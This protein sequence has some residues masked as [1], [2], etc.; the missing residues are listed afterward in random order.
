MRD[1]ITGTCRAQDGARLAV[2]QLGDPQ[3][4]PLLLLPGQA[5]SHRWW[6]RLRDELAAE[7]RTI[8]FDYR[9]TGDS[10]R[11]DE[12]DER[13]W[14]TTVFAR[15]AVS[16]LDSLGIP[17]AGVYGTSMGGRVAQMLVLDHPQRVRR[18]VLACT[19]PGGRF[20]VERDNDVRRA[21]A[22]RD[23][24]RRLAA[25]I[26]LF[27]S[28][29]GAP[30]FGPGSPL[31]GD[32]TMSAADSAAHLMV[33]AEHDACDRLGEIDTPTLVL[34]GDADRMVPS[35]NAKVIAEAILGAELGY[36]QSGRHGFFEE[37][38]DVIAPRLLDFFS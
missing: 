36:I 5:N 9:A 7:F 33:S 24:R 23:D 13:S 28:P 34:H 20:S 27:Y 12:L 38:A 18:L 16:V 8:T 19:S 3:L 37:F 21:L 1:P 4:P 35:A 2:Q 22:D 14:S 31:F 10:S 15:D 6:S 11:A 25:V 30:T 17:E 26:E 32:P 29:E